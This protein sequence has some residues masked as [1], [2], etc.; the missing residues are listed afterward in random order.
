[1]EERTGWQGQTESKIIR[2][3][4][5]NDRLVGAAKISKELRLQRQTAKTTK[6]CQKPPLPKGKGTE[7]S[8]LSTRS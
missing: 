6:G 4:K 7:P 5:R 2:E 8:F 1:M 3:E